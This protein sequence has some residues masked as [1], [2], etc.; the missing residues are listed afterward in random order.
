MLM[1][2]LKTIKKKKGWS[3]YRMSQELGISQTS[4]KHYEEQPISNR[5][6][7]LVRSQR[8][9][10]LSLETFWNMLTKEVDEAEEKEG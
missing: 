2:L 8:L 5:E 4:L 1:Q 10:G 7:I 9:S 3:D 6:K